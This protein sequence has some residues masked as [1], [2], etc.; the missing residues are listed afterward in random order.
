[1]K[2]LLIS[3]TFWS[4]YNFRLGLVKKLI[5]KNVNLYIASYPDGYEKKLKKLGAKIHIIKIF[6]KNLNPL[7]EFKL[8]LNINKVINSVKPNFIFNFTIKPIIYCSL[9]SQFKKNIKIINTLDGFGLS[10]SKNY[11]F[12]NMILFLFKLSQKKI[13][14]FFCVNKVDYNFLKKKRVIPNN[15]LKKINGTGVDL[16]YFKYSKLNN[17]HKTIFIFIGRFLYLKGIVYYFEASEILK[18][19]FKKNVEFFALGSSLYDKYSLSKEE[20]IFWKKKNIVKIIK[21]VD[22]IRKFVKKSDCVVLPTSYPEGLPKSLLEAA[23]SGRPAIC[24]KNAGC[25]EIVKNNFNGLIANIRNSKDLS[26][27]MIKFHNYNY[28]KKQSM[29]LNA[30]KLCIQKFDEKKVF[31]QYIRFLNL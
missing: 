29:S 13:H 15:T 12:K 20:I 25:N 14:T 8:I 7:K 3:N 5:N 10:F 17:N 26:K 27:L 6:S 24:N 31:D 23:S 22:D 9:V 19:K 4:I 1:M 16:N 30:R 18:K 11:I 21:S 28:K 2:V